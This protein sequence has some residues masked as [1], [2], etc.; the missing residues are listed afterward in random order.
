MT[1]ANCET[2]VYCWR[3]E[4]VG[5][6]ECI[7][8]EDFTEEEIVKYDEDMEDGCPHYEEAKPIDDYTYMCALENVI[9]S[10]KEL[11]FTT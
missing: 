7:C 4:S 6:R 5:Y 9:K 10:G 11:K 8:K 2:C 1:K 3:D